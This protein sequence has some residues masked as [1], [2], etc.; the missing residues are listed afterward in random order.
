[1]SGGA[2]PVYCS[3]PL[4]ADRAGKPPT[5]SSL[6]DKKRVSSLLRSTAARDPVRATTTAADSRC[7]RRRSAGGDGGTTPFRSARS[8]EDGGNQ[9]NIAASGA[10]NRHSAMREQL[11]KKVASVVAVAGPHV[12]TPDVCRER[13][14]RST[15]A[16]ELHTSKYL[17]SKDKEQGDRQQNSGGGRPASCGAASHAGEKRS[18]GHRVR[19]NVCDP[20]ELLLTL[21]ILYPLAEPGGHGSPPDGDLDDTDGQH[22]SCRD[23]RSDCPSK[24][25]PG[26]GERG[27]H[28]DRRGCGDDRNRGTGRPDLRQSQVRRHSSRDGRLCGGPICSDLPRLVLVLVHGAQHKRL[29]ALR[30]ARRRGEEERA[31]PLF[32]PQATTNKAVCKARNAA[33]GASNQ[34]AFR[35]PAW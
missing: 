33:S 16:Q 2:F 29:R 9:A 19:R 14:R 8:D 12:E 18:Q 22:E 26:T 27:E 30:F 28:D 34:T 32:R 24:S 3:L 4:A 5:L 10:S 11:Q 17:G 31:D 7:S 25:R 20:G 6:A 23:E 21:Q 15:R 13:T 1:M 35:A